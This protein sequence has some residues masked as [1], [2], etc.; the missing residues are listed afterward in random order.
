MGD[1]FFHLFI[2]YFIYLVYVVRNL[3][4]FSFLKVIVAVTLHFTAR[5]PAGSRCPSIHRGQFDPQRLL[6]GVNQFRL[7]FIDE[8]I[9]GFRI[10][11][12]VK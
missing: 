9:V 11:A 6:V 7:V 3:K 8:Q 12:Q 5:F 2:T 1:M 10:G 4:C